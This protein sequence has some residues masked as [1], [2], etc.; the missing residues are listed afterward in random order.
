MRLSRTLVAVLLVG[1][2]LLI[3]RAALALPAPMC[4]M[5]GD[6][7]N[8]GNL[9]GASDTGTAVWSGLGLYGSDYDGRDAA[10]K[11][12]TNGAQITDCYSALFPGY[13]PNT[14]ETASVYFPTGYIISDG[15][16]EIAMGDFQATANGPEPSTGYGAILMNI[17]G[18]AL[19]P[20]TQSLPSDWND[21]Y[22]ITTIRSLV[23]TPAQIA[24]ANAAGQVIINFDH[25]P[26]GDFI[27]FD[28]FRL[29]AN[30][31]PVPVPPTA[32]MLGSGLLGLVGLRFRKNRG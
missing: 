5:V 26:S 9:A 16:I 11:A 10:E 8:Y 24:A 29:C 30:V 12:A 22:Q 20:A 21:N 27:A 14:S 4:F 7:D 18:I 23:L 32:I 17:N 15:I 25:T 19:D 1:G 13:G 28:W 3:S 6:V 2:L 31:E